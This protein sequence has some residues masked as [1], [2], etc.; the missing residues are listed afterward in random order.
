MLSGR[1]HT[2]QDSMEMKKTK[3][4]KAAQW[5][6][7]LGVL[8]VKLGVGEPFRSGPADASGWDPEHKPLTFV[9]NP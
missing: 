5:P 7:H 2:T 3:S 6:I 8:C 9:S 1:Y 4:P